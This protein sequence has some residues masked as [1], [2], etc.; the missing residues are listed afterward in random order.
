MPGDRR[1]QE[2]A[3]QPDCDAE[4]GEIRR[5]ARGVHQHPEQLW[6]WPTGDPQPDEG[7]ARHS[8]HRYRGTGKLHTQ[9]QLANSGRNSQQRRSDSSFGNRSKTSALDIASSPSCALAR[10]PLAMV[11]SCC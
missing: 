7:D 5:H 9:Q 11:G 4:V 1:P 10:D 2:Y 8:C 3:G 6:P